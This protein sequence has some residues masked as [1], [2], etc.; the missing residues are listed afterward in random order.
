MRNDREKSDRLVV[1]QKPPNNAAEPAAEV[2]EGSERTKG[3]SP[4]SHDGRTQRRI[5]P[6]DGIERVRQ[7]ARRDRKQRFTALLH[8]VYDRRP[9]AR[10]LPRPEARRRGGHRR[11][12]VAALR[13]GVGGQPPRPGG[14]HQ[15]GRVPG[16]PGSSGVH[17]E[18]GRAAAAARRSHAGRQNRPACRRRG[19]ERHLRS[20]TFSASRT[21][22]GRSAARITR[23]MRSR[24]ASRRE[25]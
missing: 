1:P 11:R 12:D 23:W 6:S 20:R 3:N 21:G 13:R 22:F 5:H 24:S 7:A 16:E 14:P 17:P 10:G 15:A 4:D 25:E 9:S 8:H 18:G 19:T 2:V